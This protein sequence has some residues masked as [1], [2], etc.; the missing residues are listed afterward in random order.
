MIR[1]IKLITL[2]ALGTFIVSCES[3]SEKTTESG[4]S[5]TVVTGGGAEI[6]DSSYLLLNLSFQDAQD[7]VWMSTVDNGFPTPVLKYDSLWENGGAVN[8][9][10]NVLGEGDSV[11]FDVTG[12]QLFVETF[13]RPIPPEVDSA[14]VFTF[15]V[16]V[17]D[18]LDKEGFKT[19]QQQM[20]VKQ[21]QKQAEEA[22]KQLEEDVETIDNYLAKND[23]EAEETESG[24]RYVITEEGDGP[25]AEVGDTVRVNYVGKVLNGDYFDTS[26]KEIAQEQ[27][28]YD[29]RREP[30]EPFQLTLGKGMV[31]KGWD[32][33]LT[34]LNEG[35]K[36]TLYIPSP[37]AYGPRA[38]SVALGANSILVFDVEL[39]EVK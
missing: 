35:G 31:I 7:S 39:I 11:T 4:V 22:E 27:G 30:Y 29:E 24:L 33:G 9:V 1:S 3:S 37:L 15:N 38:R 10:F 18:V 36:A 26:F 6:A 21:R 2:L 12:T 20:M 16:G 19:W 25:S 8:Q 23:I 5:Y 34:Y 17:E 32:E 28:L 13:N 14:D